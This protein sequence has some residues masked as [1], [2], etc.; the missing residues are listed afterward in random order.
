MSKSR[1]V[2]TNDNKNN[3]YFKKAGYEVV[4]T[5]DLNFR[6]KVES[7]SLIFIQEHLQNE[8]LQGGHSL[9]QRMIQEVWSV[10]AKVGIISQT[11]NFK[12]ST[13]EIQTLRYL[14]PCYKRPLSPNTWKQH[15]VSHGYTERF[16][17]IKRKYR[18]EHKQP[19]LT[20]F[21]QFKRIFF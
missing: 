1:I 13:S 16:N 11:N 6:A 9:L 18:K 12:F 5:N 2:I 8:R 7:A 14:L 21:Q 19:Q 17:H 20:S 4:H 3:I 15:L 10:E